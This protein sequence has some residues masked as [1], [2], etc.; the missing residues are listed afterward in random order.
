MFPTFQRPA[1]LGFLQSLRLRSVILF[2]I[3]FFTVVMMPRI[4]TVMNSDLLAGY[5]AAPFEQSSIRTIVENTFADT[6]F[7]VSLTHQE[8]NFY[9]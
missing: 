3:G 1:F 9:Q 4:T 5:N 7:P 8:P 6:T 2:A